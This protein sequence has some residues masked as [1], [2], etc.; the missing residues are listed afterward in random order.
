MAR[1]R[2]ETAP[3][4]TVYD[5][6]FVIK[7]A[8]NA[9]A[10]LIQ[11][12]NSSGANVGN[13]SANGILTVA[14]VI[15]SNAGTASTDLATRG[16]VDSLAAGTNWHAAV[17]WGTNEPLPACVYHNGT[18]GVGATLIGNAFGALVVDGAT[19]EQGESLLIKD[20]VD[21]KQNG[22]YTITDTGGASAYF[23]LTRREDADNSP[24]GE[25]KP[26][27]AV[28]VVNGAATVGNSYVVTSEGTGTGGQISIGV[29][30]ITYSIFAGTA[31][32]QA[33]AGLTRTGYVIN[34]ISA[35][36]AR[37]QVN[38]NSIDLATVN[39]TSNGGSNTT[40]FVD[41]VATDSYGR[42]TGVRSASVDFTGFALSANSVLTGTPTAPTAPNASTST[43]QIATTE[44]VQARALIAESNA[45]N[46]A[47][48]I[49]IQKSILDAKGDIIVGS[50]D[51]TF[52][53]LSVGTNGHFLRANSSAGVGIEWASIPTI[54][55]LD[56]VGDV[57]ITTATSGQFLK[58]NGSAWINELIPALNSIDDITGVTITDL[59]SG[60]FL[61][62]N[63]SAWVNDL[64]DLGTDT[65]GNYVSDVTAGTGITISHTQGEGSTANVSITNTAVTAGSYTYPSI[66]VNAQGQL[67]AASNGTAPVTSVT[68]GTGVT[69][70][71]T[72][73]PTISIGQSV[74]T[75]ASVSFGTISTD[76]NVTVG[77]NL[78]VTGTTTT[79]NQ[80]SLN[81]SDPLIYLNGGSE[82][83]DPD[84]GFAGNYND[85]TYRHAG[86][87][88]DASDS[89]KF[90][91]FKGLTVE[92]TAPINTAHGSYAAADVVANTFESTV[93][94]GTAPFTVAS[95]TV[96]TNLNA[97]LLDGQSSA[98]Y[99]PIDGPTF[100]G[101]VTL[102]AN[103]VTSAMIAEGTVVNADIS[104][105]AA[106]DQN[107]IADT[108][109]NQQ[110]AS[111]TLVLNDKNKMVE[112]SN[113]SATTL[114]I[115]ADNSVNFATG[116]TIV[117]L[118]TNTGQITLT[119]G[120]GVTLNATPGAKL[121][122]QWSSA[123]LVKR[124]ANTWVALGDLSA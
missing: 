43:T 46:S 89:H 124:A 16:Y 21:A 63:G 68:G 122:T 28:Y 81:I 109:L 101:T 104:A 77:G 114:T 4:I 86:L 22:I 67:T 3:E 54:N 76:G 17:A 2:I 27:D 1:L 118:Q 106:I 94:T 33:G 95:T 78:I 23:V 117:I 49:F 115:P 96:V 87:F 120:A 26:G 36:A 40:T 41:N 110:T 102:P 97:D 64:I 10:P 90:K 12:K 74:A 72:T 108:I 113:T 44:F 112:I 55:N 123:T 92:P 14:S 60:N 48:N 6:A 83:T 103:T 35:D 53:K 11:L 116:A 9:T 66:T 62:Y 57:T 24:A 38:A 61:K 56:D 79:V 111:Y 13:I 32:T 82:I 58:Y 50:A 7:A 30:N 105:T 19:V 93:A 80:T 121:R 75:N 100:T 25:V 39:V 85:G 5:E 65:V 37:I 52:S 42:V 15:A 98:Y 91:F 119:A 107:K 45:A 59:A 34:V 8:A 99:A 31:A 71:G 70:S 29:D 88:S 51:D 73:T 47:A 18:N 20:Q 69:I 84:L